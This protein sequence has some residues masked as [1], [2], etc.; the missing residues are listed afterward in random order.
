MWPLYWGLAAFAS[1]VYLLTKLSTR[2]LA[3]LIGLPLT[4]EFGLTALAAHGVNNRYLI[5][6]DPFYLI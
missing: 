4:A 2:K 1:L 6:H 3:I 5:Y